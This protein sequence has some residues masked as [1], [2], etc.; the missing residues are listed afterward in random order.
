M[1]TPTASDVRAHIAAYLAGE[2]SLDEF[3]AWLV[4]ATWSVDPAADQELQ[5][6]VGEVELRMAEFDHGDW[7]EEELRAHF[8]RLVRASFIELPSNL[9]PLH[10]WTWTGAKTSV[11]WVRTP[12][13]S[14][15]AP[16]AAAPA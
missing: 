15:V 3:C 9:Q 13:G 1:P 11:H 7:S 4:P 6:I 16:H 2:C 10:V 12:V 14:F 5:N 8:A